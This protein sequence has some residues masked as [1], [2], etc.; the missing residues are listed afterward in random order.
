MHVSVTVS[1]SAARI[2][3]LPAGRGNQLLVAATV[4]L[5][6]VLA[7]FVIADLI[8][9][10]VPQ[11]DEGI[12]A[13]KVHDVFSSHP[14]LQGQRSTSDLSTP[15]VFAHHPGPA[16]FYLLALPYAMTGYLPAGLLIGCLLV[17]VA[18]IVVAVRAAYRTG[19]LAGGWL[20]VAVFALLIAGFRSYLVEPWNFYFP[21]LGLVTV[22]VLAWRLAVGHSDALIAYVAFASL[23]AQPHI[24]L[25]PPI[26]CITVFVAVIGLWQ[27][28][29]RHDAMW[30]LSAIHPLH[31]PAWW[32]RRGTIAVAVAALCWAPVIA[33]AVSFQPNNLLEMWHVVV[34]AGSGSTDTAVRPAG[35]PWVS[36]RPPN[37][38]AR[39][40]C[41][42]AGRQRTWW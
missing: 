1:A 40:S 16:Q 14:P 30:P 41:R 26:L 9:G 24:A 39:W 21:L 7:G 17:Q 34:G 20:V 38:W 13:V 33:E 3:A 37:P 27:W 36:G 11:G 15:G 31:R 19:G 10:W 12:I 4:L 29:L 18:C 25:L 32:R 5:C 22:I 28:G 35:T 8:S 23:W 42:G 6:L 2:R